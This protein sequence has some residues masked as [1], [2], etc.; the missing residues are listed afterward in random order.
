MAEEVRFPLKKEILLWALKE[1]QVD[2]DEVFRK[3]TNLEKWINGE[4][5]PTFKQ[6]ESLANY[7]KIPF[8]YMFLWN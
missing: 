7:L 6:I 5:H 1:A 3:F 8:G 4:K 2:E